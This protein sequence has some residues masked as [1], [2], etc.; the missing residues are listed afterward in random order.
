VPKKS[1][2]ENRAPTSAARPT[3]VPLATAAYT[4]AASA[5]RVETKVAPS[6][7]VGTVRTWTGGVAKDAPTRG[8]GARSYAREP[9]EPTVAKHVV[10]FRALQTGPVAA[11]MDAAKM[12]GGTVA[13]QGKAV[14]AAFSAECQLLEKIA[15]RQK[16][17][18]VEEFQGML[19][20]VG[21]TIRAVSSFIE[22]CSP[23]D[24]LFNH[25]TA[26]AESI[27][28]LGWVAAEDRP[29]SVVLEAEGAGDFYFSKALMAGK[30]LPNAKQ[31]QEFVRAFRDVVD[32]LK[33][34]IKE[35]HTTGLRWNLGLT[36]SAANAVFSGNDYG[37]VEEVDEDK[38]GCD[39]V[40]AFS[41]IIEGP[42]AAYAAA[43]AALGPE[44]KAQANAFVAAWKAEAAVL[45][46]AAVTPKP[47]EPDFSPIADQMGKVS[48]LAQEYAPRGP[49]AYHMTAV[50]DSVSALG[51]VAVDSGA[52][53]F[54]AEQVGAGQFFI[55]KVKMGAKKSNSPAQHHTWAAAIEHLFA[56][57]KAYVKEYHTVALQWNP[58]KGAKTAKRGLRRAAVA[59]DEEP[60]LADPATD[61]SSLISGPLARY[62]SASAALDGHLKTQ[63]DAFTAAWRAEEVFLK[64]AIVSPKPA[65][66]N[67]TPIADQMG[68]VS[69]LAQQY[70][71]RGPFS[72]HMTAVG[73]S[74]SALGW[75]A[76]DSG[77]T[78]FVADQAGA[79]Q[80][81]IDKV[82]MGAKKTDAP[83][84]HQAWAAA[85]EDLFAQL[86]AY[87]KT[88]HTA[89]LQWNSA[90]FARR[91][92]SIS[93]G[94]TAVSEAPPAKNSLS[95]FL[96]FIAGPV[97]IC[98]K[99]GEALSGSAAAQSR[100]MF[101]AFKAEYKFLIKAASQDKPSEDGF[102]DLVDPVGQA[103]GSVVDAV[104][105]MNPRDAN[106]HVMTAVAESIPALGW[107]AVESN[108]KG[109]I[110]EYI[111]AGGFYISKA[112][113][114][115]RTMPAADKAKTQAFVRSFKE[116]LTQ[117][118]E[119]VKTHHVTG[120]K[121]NSGVTAPA[122]TPF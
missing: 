111:E 112:L 80:F 93:R 85:L 6:E 39:S 90:N 13:V 94:R 116:L 71:P 61:F 76:V 17:L 19:G 110:A 20:D 29:V 86:K 121:W 67:F 91:P 8:G 24:P 106:F 32:A 100:A 26:V 10:H 64:M 82:K 40:S 62:V 11:F 122:S 36:G 72:N 53:N 70:A 102:A 31:H 46:K 4:R 84:Q 56:E 109:F 81:F 88:H 1:L 89:S 115:A 101:D 47:A 50:G 58:P 120:L 104:A 33:A 119:Y 15:V 28:M 9:A 105:G 51:W 38:T 68:K 57:L 92:R 54:V 41:A 75:I 2:R 18:S 107:I 23:R 114:D 37:D 25:L 65:E 44:L 59:D 74:V 34:F 5:T 77:A 99:D 3:L 45:K 14:G 113:M 73:D 52:A 7:K 27:P 95:A 43:S 87:V 69:E 63:A 48:E 103:M 83:A 55:D 79:G 35:H 96:S 97:K 21:T 117:L 30:K 78:N 98:V 12:L 16:P 22:Q 118:V 42:L 66:P 108:P 60:S 49:L